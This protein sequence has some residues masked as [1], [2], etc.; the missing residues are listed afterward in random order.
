[1]TN[2]PLVTVVV[3]TR[4]SEPFLDA[5]LKSIAEQSYSNIELIVVDRNSTD[6]TKEI[7]LKYTSADK[8]LNTEPER[9]TQRNLGA[10]TATGHY[11]LMIDSDMVLSE[12]VV[13]DCVEVMAANSEAAGV[14]IPEESF[15][16]GFWSQCKKLER[17][18]YIGDDSVEAARFFTTELYHTLDGYNEKMIAGEDWDLSDRSREHGDILRVESL[19]YHNEAKINL[20]KTLKKKFYYSR[21]AASYFKN[22]SKTEA[23]ANRLNGALGRYFTFFS[24]PKKLLE[25]PLVG[26]GMIFMKTCEFTFGAAGLVM[27][28]IKK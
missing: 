10:K 4:N 22:E 26:A 8:V 3:P 1:M 17:S 24:K 2:Q 25:D 23:S 19:I 15:G 28:K 27:G 13:K 14:I 5:C 16:E 7:A 18:F 20:P 11:I 9:S 21:Q 6:A 12:D